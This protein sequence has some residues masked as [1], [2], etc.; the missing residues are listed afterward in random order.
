METLINSLRSVIGTPQFYIEGVL[1]LGAAT[2]YMLAGLVVLVV[3]SSV[4]RI[5]IRWCEK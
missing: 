1:N 3:V 4:F 5:L 2:E